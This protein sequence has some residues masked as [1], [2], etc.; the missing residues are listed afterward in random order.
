MDIGETE[1]VR[2]GQHCDRCSD[3]IV[4]ITNEIT[5]QMFKG[6]CGKKH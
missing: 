3:I 1:I 5:N 4:I 6:K 2:A